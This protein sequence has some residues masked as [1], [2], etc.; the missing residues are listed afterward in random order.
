MKLSNILK[1]IN[2]S[3]EAEV[4]DRMVQKHIDFFGMPV[5]VE[6]IR[7]GV[8]YS[9]TFKGEPWER[10][11]KCDYGYFEGITGADG[12]FLDCYVGPNFTLPES[13]VYV[14]KQMRPDGSQFDE[15]K[16]VIGCMSV[17]EAKALYLEHCHSPKVYGGIKEYTID[18][19]RK[20]IEKHKHVD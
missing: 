11:L 8:K 9:K 20:V 12:E 17:E 6:I 16:L 3:S 1:I 7:G 19:F 13:K 10:T 14:I 18:E 4:H 5:C 15:H 2:E